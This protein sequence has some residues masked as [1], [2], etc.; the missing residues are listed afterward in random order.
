MHTPGFESIQ[1]VMARVVD[2]V[3]ALHRLTADGK[4]AGVATG[5]RDLD[6]MLLGLQPGKLAIVAGGFMAGKTAFMVNAAVHATCAAGL[7]VGVFT[8]ESDSFSLARRILA[9]A[10]AMD[11]H[12]LRT[13]DLPGEYWPKMTDA[14]KRLEGA[15]LQIAGPDGL[16]T[17]KGL[18]AR[19]EALAVQYASLDLLAVDNIRLLRDA[20]A[21]RCLKRLAQALRCPVLATT[22]L[23]GPARSGGKGRPLLQGIPGEFADDADVVL[24]I[25]REEL[26]YPGSCEAGTATVTVARHRNGPMGTVRLAFDRATARF[27]DFDDRPGLQPAR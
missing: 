21:A 10:G 26:R 12:R 22:P 20:D 13:G 6:R 9:N 23:G 3:D 17:V 2:R 24:L 18:C 25:D 4:I 1:T 15:R 11:G 7:A 14:L 19:A 5:L 8:L 16:D 27:S